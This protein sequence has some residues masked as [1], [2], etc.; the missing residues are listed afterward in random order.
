MVRSLFAL[1]LIDNDWNVDATEQV[2]TKIYG[3]FYE[4]YASKYDD[5]DLSRMKEIERYLYESGCVGLDGKHGIIPGLKKGDRMGQPTFN[6]LS[7]SKAW[8]MI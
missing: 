8:W 7:E 3:V 4:E 1:I 5:V 6:C 2:F